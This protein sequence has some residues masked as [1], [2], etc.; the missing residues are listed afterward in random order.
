MHNFF[1]YQS[2]LATLTFMITMNPAWAGF[3]K[4]L[5]GVIVLVVVSYLADSAHL[6]GILNPTLA[7]LAAAVFSGL[8]SKLKADSSNTTALFGAVKLS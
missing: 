8:E 5:L 1:D 2:L 4:G 6:T 7:T 3:L